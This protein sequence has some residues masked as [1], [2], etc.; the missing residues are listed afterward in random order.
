MIIKRDSYSKEDLCLLLSETTVKII[1]N[2]EDR[3]GKLKSFDLNFNFERSR[4]TLTERDIG[5]LRSRKNEE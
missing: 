1:Q 3:N 5:S 4:Y 2:I